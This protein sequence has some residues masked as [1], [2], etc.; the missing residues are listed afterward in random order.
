MTGQSGDCLDE[1]LVNGFDVHDEAW[2]WQDTKS[3]LGGTRTGLER[4]K[5]E[6]RRNVRDSVFRIG[7]GH[8]HV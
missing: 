8:V 2:C 7:G 4:P 6:V 5:C 1:I 3:W